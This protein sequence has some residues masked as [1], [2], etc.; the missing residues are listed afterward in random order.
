MEII[1]QTQLDEC[2]TGEMELDQ[3]LMQSAIKEM[4]AHS[5]A[6]R[7]A[8]EA[9]DYEAWRSSAHRGVGGNATLGFILLAEQFRNA[10]NHTATDPERAAVLGRINELIELTQQ[11]LVRMGLL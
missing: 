3:D 7:N 8:L 6:M 10:E 11:E 1:N 2:L 5:S 9:Q 4:K